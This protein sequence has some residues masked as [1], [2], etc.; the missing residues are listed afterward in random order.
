MSDKAPPSIAQRVH[1]AGQELVSIPDLASA[2]NKTLNRL[3]GWPYRAA[4]GLVLDIRGQ[5]TEILGTLIYAQSAKEVGVEPVEIPA[6]SVACAIDVSDGMDL[7]GFRDAYARIV[8]V[9][10]LKKSPAPQ[11]PGTAHTTVTLGL[12]V[13]RQVSVPVEALAEELDR[14]NRQ[15]PSAHWPDM[16]VVLSTAT[17]SYAVQF[18]GERIMGDFLPPAEGAVTSGSVPPMYIILSM[19]PTGDYTFNRM[20]AFVIAHLAI[21]SPG[22]ALPNWADILAETPK[23]TLVL[24]GY[25]YNLSGQ[26]VPVPPQFYNDRYFPPPPLR[27]E[28]PQGDL[29][30]TIQFLPWQDGG[31]VLLRGKLP[32]EGLLVFLGKEALKGK[33]TRGDLQISYVLPIAAQDFTML[34]QR[35]RMQSNL[36]VRNDPTQWVVQKFADEGSSSPFMARLFMGI[37]RLRDAVFPDVTKREDFDKAYEFILMNLLSTRTAAQDIVKLFREHVQQVTE[38]KIARRQGQVL[39]ID[40]SIDKE[41]RKQVENFLN[42][43]VRVLKQG[44]QEVA[45]TL[46]INVGFLFKKPGAFANGIVSLQR[47]DPDL[48]GYLQQTRLWSE[49][50]V[51][52]R[53]AIEHTSSILPKVRYVASSASILVVEPQISNQ[54][55][56]EFV[57]FMMDRLA[58]FVEEVTAH[59]LQRLMPLGLSIREIPL[60]E[61]VPEMPE[62][63]QNILR[64]GGIPIWRLAY[65]QTTFEEN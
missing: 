59:C 36:T 45:S 65:H 63:F 57:A 5:K 33:I 48:A 13:A 49:R 18:P 15:S 19:R 29:L 17:I 40:E 41:L 16:V 61:R 1:D 46:Q 53:N 34:L 28:D 43:A 2:L 27:L 60:A 35:I 32:L 7:Q 51:E 39:H 12:I 10:R 25:Q 4:S 9:K 20:C 26:L 44:M 56:S 47:L 54:P 58:C 11:I 8:Q 52:S 31:V 30:S 62:R 64:S 14:L 37:M 38:G 24:R 6:D 22:A 23:D 21:F 3:L 50:L 55:A 42:G